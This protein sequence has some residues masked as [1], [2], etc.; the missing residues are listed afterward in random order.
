MACSHAQ[1]DIGM[2]LSPPVRRRIAGEVGW[3]IV[4]T[5]RSMLLRC[6]IFSFF[7]VP[8]GRVGLFALSEMHMNQKITFQ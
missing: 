6:R 3:P 8:S 5:Q 1:H 4:W 7:A 2:V